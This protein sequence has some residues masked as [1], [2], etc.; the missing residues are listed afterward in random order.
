MV[1]AVDG[2]GGGRPIDLLQGM[3]GK[4]ERVLQ[5]KVERIIRDISKSVK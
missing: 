1:G 3:V 5:T 2:L 4:V